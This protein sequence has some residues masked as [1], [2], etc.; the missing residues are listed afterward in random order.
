MTLV[1]EDNIQ[2]AVDAHLGG[3][4]QAEAA[5]KYNVS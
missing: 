1:H 4:I 5:E 2:S 3:L